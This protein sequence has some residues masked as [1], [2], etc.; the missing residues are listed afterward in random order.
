MTTQTKTNTHSGSALDGFIKMFYELLK[1]TVLM[2]WYFVSGIKKNAKK[3]K[4]DRGMF[5]MA[6]IGSIF[7]AKVDFY[8]SWWPYWTPEI[9]ENLLFWYKG[10][11]GSLIYPLTFFGVFGFLYYAIIGKTESDRI[12]RIKDAVKILSKGTDSE[13]PKVIRIQR[14]NSYKTK[15]VVESP[16]VGVDSFT[17]AQ[18]DLESSFNQQIEK[19]ERASSPRYIN[20][21]L[22]TKRLPKKFSYSSVKDYCEKPCHF[23]LG[24][25][26]SGLMTQDLTEL[27]HMLIAGT[28]SFGKSNFFKQVLTHLLQ[29]TNHMQMHLIDLKGG[30]EMRPFKD[31]PNVNFIN[32]IQSAVATLARIKTEMDERF[33]HLYVNGKN[34]IVP[35]RDKKDRI[36]VAIDEASVLYMKKY[37]QSAEGNAALEARKITD[38]L[39]KLARA[40]GINL[41]IATQ[42]VTKETL[43]THIRENMSG[44]VSFKANDDAASRTVLGNNM[45]THLPSVKGRAIFNFGNTYEEFQ[46][47]LITDEEIESTVNELRKEFVE[48]TKKIFQPELITNAVVTSQSEVKNYGKGSAKK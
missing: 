2:L 10:L 22:N 47:P 29:N 35:K 14:I 38:D 42:K 34:T 37:A 36:I 11:V 20:I 40:A 27:P 4:E 21:F 9:F 3:I 25:G 6:L 44:R 15:V 7:I 13:F 26:N 33:D 46:A 5:A 16:F 48:G 41:I 31:L 32:D 8:H 39:A 1:F 12:K 19:I 24:E 43:D 45:A 28:T 18:N 17:K 30:L 23:I